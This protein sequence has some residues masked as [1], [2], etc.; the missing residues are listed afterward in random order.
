MSAD[1]WTLSTHE[2]RLLWEEFDA[3]DY[4]IEFAYTGQD[5][6]D[7]GP[8]AAQAPS[9]RLD[10][11]TPPQRAALSALCR[12]SITI[13]V[14][15][16]DAARPFEDPKHHLRLLSA[17][18]DNE[19]VYIARQ[20]LG[21]S[22]SL[23]ATVSITRHAFSSWTRDLVAMIPPGTEVGSLPADTAVGFQAIPGV[24]SMTIPV[25]VA[26]ATPTAAT[27]FTH[28]HPGVCGS[29]RLQVGTLANGGR[30]TSLEVRYRDIP[31]DGRYLLIV[32]SPGA[33]LPIDATRFAKTLNRV[34]NTIRARHDTA[35]GA[36]S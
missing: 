3:G 5:D 16:I 30:P 27:A 22:V 11:L 33:A 29:I 14:T 18:D 23:G 2:F 6:V 12:P 1:A 36:A 31:D 10:Q 25:V 15:G 19:H 32:D 26:P 4:P 28:P 9:I 21:S 24:E 13:A 17:T 20:R 7:R 35:R 34:I 8:D